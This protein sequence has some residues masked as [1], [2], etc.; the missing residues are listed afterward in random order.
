MAAPWSAAARS[1]SA[2]ASSMSCPAAP[3]MF[4]SCHRQRRARNRRHQRQLERFHWHGV[5]LRWGQSCQSCAVH[6]PRLGHLRCAYDQLQLCFSRWQRDADGVERRGGC[7]EHRVHRQLLVSELPRHGWIRRHRQ[8]HRS[9]GRE[10]RQ[11]PIECGRYLPAAGIDLPDIAFGAQTT[12][13]YS[14]NATGA[15]GT[16]TMSDGR[17]AAS[18]ALLGNYIGG[19]FVAV[20]DGHGGTLVTQAQPQ[21]QPLLTRPQA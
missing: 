17:H 9:G 5:R 21:Q 20:A 7:G 13:A 10:R 1:W 6:R 14:Q 4:A 8:D 19:S 11:R 18:V 12:L 3:P 16:L 15:G 2:T